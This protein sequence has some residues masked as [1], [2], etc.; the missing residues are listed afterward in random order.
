MEEIKMTTFTKR[1]VTPYRY[2]IVG[3][4]L[5]PKELVKARKNFEEG[6]INQEELTAVEDK[7]I[8]ELIQKQVDAGLKSVTDGEFR[9]SWWHLDFFWG[10]GGVEK[11]I[12]QSGGYVFQGIR[13]R[14]EEAEIVA[15]LNGENHPFVE[16]FKFL[17]ENTPEGIEPRI[18]VPAPAQFISRLLG[19]ESTE[20]FY[21]T[22]EDL[23]KGIVDAYV[24]VI[25]DLKEAGAHT[26]QFDD[27]SW[28]RLVNLAEELSQD[29]I[30]HLKDL[31]LE[32][33]NGVFKEVKDIINVTTHLCRGNYRSTWFSEG[34]YGPFADEVFKKEEVHAYYLEFDT[35]RAGG[36]EPLA[37]VSD[38]KLVVLGLVTSKSPELEDKD[39]IIKRI[40]EASK[41]VDLDRLCLSPQCG[42]AST[43]EGNDLTEEEQWAKIKL[44]REIAEE[45]WAD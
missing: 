6:K 29:E 45:V 40:E 26:V 37:E 36:F 41:Y 39:E 44:V 8:K 25:K 3:S 42:F 16:H 24:Q 17:K 20:R 43:E 28:G 34:S 1:T 27:C 38:D 4:F 18:T 9:R 15:L 14:A 11:I 35:D 13:A 31:Y 32:V 10:L 22:E 19:K 12:P 7:A 30:E 2:D 21:P 33:N 5:R 23:V